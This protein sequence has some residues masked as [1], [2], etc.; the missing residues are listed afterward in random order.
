LAGSTPG[1]SAAG[2][3]LLRGDGSLASLEEVVDF[4]DRGGNAN[5]F[6]DRKLRHHE[7]ETKFERVRVAGRKYEGPEVRL[8][9]PNRKPIAPLEL[10]LAA[11]EKSDLVFFLKALHGDPVDRVVSDRTLLVGSG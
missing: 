8:L 5:A 7:A 4:Y 9:G 10:N 11:H 1:R 6:L 2:G 3:V